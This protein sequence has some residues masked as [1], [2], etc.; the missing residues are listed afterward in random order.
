MG[1]YAK[2]EN[3]KGQCPTAGFE[4]CIE[5]LSCDLGIHKPGS[6][7]SRAGGGGAAIADDISLTIDYE[8]SMPDIQKGLLEGKPIPKVELF[9]TATIDG[10][11]NTIFLTYTFTD[12]HFT[13][14]QIS[15]Q[16]TGSG[17]P[18]TVNLSVSYTTI[19][20]NYVYFD[21]KGKKKNVPASK[22]DVR[23]GE[24]A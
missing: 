17:E 11:A 20:C 2:L 16:G 21:E 7:G 24:P 3:Y 8:K 10:K 15:G 22:F 5:L 6:A 13:G 9:F 12:C 23:K 14:F 1:V 4:D 19:E 18:P